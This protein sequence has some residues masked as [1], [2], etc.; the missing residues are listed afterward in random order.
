MEVNCV[1]HGGTHVLHAL[2]TK[3][4]A[5]VELC[6]IKQVECDMR[7]GCKPWL[8]LI[9]PA[10]HVVATEADTCAEGVVVSDSRNDATRWNFIIAEYSNVFEPPGMPTERDTVH[11]IELK[12]GS[13]PPYKW[14]YRVS[15]AELAEVRWQLDKYLE[16]GWIHP[17]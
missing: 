9:Q 14:Q 17:F 5:K 8:M 2:P 11:R 10:T 12:P 1:E 6:S 13:V 15:A 7:L 4:V 16:K 3:P